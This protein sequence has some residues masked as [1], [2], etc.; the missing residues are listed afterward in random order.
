MQELMMRIENVSMHFR[1][2][3][4]KVH[5]LKE[6]LIRLLKR[7][8]SYSDFVALDQVS[9]EVYKGERLGIIGPNGAGKSTLL[10][11][12]AGVMKPTSGRVQIH[13]S[14]APLLE[15][16]AGFDDEFSG[17]KNIYL[18][19]AILGKSKQFLDDHYEEM[20]AFSE[21]EHFID[22]ALK[23][24]SSGMRAKLGFSIA[25][26]ASAD[27]LIVDE[28][29]GVG[30]EAF[31]KKSSQKMAQLIEEGRTVLMVSH[32]LSQMVEL[33]DRIVW[34]D[35]GRIRAI[36]DPEEICR[37]YEAQSAKKR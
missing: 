35:H 24:Y 6:Y 17:A 7:D 27:I 25:S 34:L 4:E 30:D 3:N 20:V 23:Y 19:G 32:S 8:L 21:L 26:L 15:L 37:Q 10:K 29:L 5:S 33:S 31:R 12:I 22:K 2:R 36:G 18:N 13:G 28:I 14:V 9:F 11:I 16:G 1:L